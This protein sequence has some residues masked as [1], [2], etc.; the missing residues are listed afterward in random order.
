MSH[1]RRI[2]AY[3][4]GLRKG[5]G[6]AGQA[7]RL[8]QAAGMR[9]R[10]NWALPGGLVIILAIII[11]WHATWATNAG[12]IGLWMFRIIVIDYLVFVF[13]WVCAWSA[14][15]KWRRNQFLLED[16]VVTNL[17]PSVVGNLL[18]AGGIA[19]W[20]TLL[21]I[22]FLVD[23]F[24]LVLLPERFGAM[25]LLHWDVAISIILLSP[26]YLFLAWFHL[27]TIR[28]AYWMFAVAALPRVSLKGK[29]VANFFL[30]PIYVLTLTAVGSMITAP[31]AVLLAFGQMLI[32]EMSGAITIRQDPFGSDVA[33]GLGAIPG[34]L[35]VL[36]LKRLISYQYEISFWR[37]Y[38][39]YCWYG[40]GERHHPHVYPTHMYQFLPQ[41]IAFL[42]NEEH[43]L[44]KEQAAEEA[45][46]NAP[47]PGPND[48]T[49]A[50]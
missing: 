15:W 39:L 33:W 30:I 47:P 5:F 26:V 21:F 8:A 50:P 36:L 23:I 25:S 20:A 16:L 17:R 43:A 2:P 34:L 35:L 19:I 48:A 29:A 46:R 14:V 22:L 40:A 49:S 7:V 18:F 45:A 9:R 31:A 4:L 37:S 1:I 24:F 41:W 11:A 28:I 42:R 12:G 38:L 27:E 3:V 13:G 10:F 6:P 32:A 44:A